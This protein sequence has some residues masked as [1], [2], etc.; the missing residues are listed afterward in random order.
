MSRIATQWCN[1]LLGVARDR[2]FHGEQ[3][4]QVY[5]SNQTKRDYVWNVVG[6]GCWGM[7]FPVLTI[8]VTQISG[9]DLAGMFSMAYVVACL[10]MILASFGIRTYQVSDIDETYSFAEYRLNRFITCIA[11][12]FAGYLYCM[13]RGYDGDMTTICMGMLVYK[14]IDGLAAEEE[15]AEDDGMH[16]VPVEEG[17]L[18]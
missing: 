15:L 1:R 13:A 2:S 18:L 6:M 7:V 14:V 4:E 17:R 11:A 5:E 16:E 3:Q 9:A 12:V 10:L 8:V